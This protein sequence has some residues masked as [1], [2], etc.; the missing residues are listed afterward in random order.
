MK[1]ILFV[2]SEF[3]SGMIPFATTIINT[4]AKD[5]D[6]EVYC[7]CVNS[8]K[9][10]YKGRI[11]DMAHPVYIEYPKNKMTKLFYKFWPYEIVHKINNIRDIVKPDIVHFLTGDFTLALYVRFFVDSTFYY[12][13]HDLYPHELYGR[14]LKNKLFNKIIRTGYK[15]CRDI[16]ENLTTSS[17]SQ[18]EE[19][20]RIYTDKH[21]GYTC[22]PSLV[23]EDIIKRG[24]EVPELTGMNNYI[25]FFGCVDK[26][27]GIDMLVDAFS[28]IDNLKK[29]KLVIAGKGDLKKRELSGNILH[30][31]RFIDDKEIKSLFEKA[32]FVVYPYLSAT[33]SGVLSIAYFFKKKMLLSDIPFFLDYASDD[34]MF[35]RVGDVS[36]LKCKLE[37]MMDWSIGISKK[38]NYRY[39]YGEQSL[40]NSYKKLYR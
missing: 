3:A 40:I 14:G 10:S 19:L 27:K 16:I 23:T 25:L 32:L 7:I 24:E 39:F 22:F 11:S 12:T 9:M 8:H 36:E 35:F 37:E 29:I 4:M 15:Q 18:I 20:K 17:Y 38:D 2:A 6:F 1:K 30:I 21:I 33:M 31:N 34:T 5:T 13:V 26:Y 28:M